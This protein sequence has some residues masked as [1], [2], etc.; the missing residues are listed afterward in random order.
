MSNVE[1]GVTDNRNFWRLNDL[2]DQTL[3]ERLRQLLVVGS[4]TQA[5]I[6]A[7]L[8]EVEARRLHSRAGYHSLFEYCLIGLG[9]SEF[10]A[11]F[12]ISAARIARNFPVA[13]ELLERGEIHLS[14]LHLL[15]LYLTPDNHAQLLEDARRKT[16]R[17]VEALIAQ[18][19]PR[20]NVP[21]NS[22]PLP[23]TEALSPG[24]QRL[25]LTVT[26]AFMA[27]LERACDR[28]SHANPTY[29]LAV[30]LERALAALH[31]DLDKGRLGPERPAPPK[32]ATDSS[33]A[34]EI[35]SKSES[36][37]QKPRVGRT[38]VP[39]AVSRAVAERDEHRCTFISADGRRCRARGFLQIHHEQP[40][41]RNGADTLE[42]LRLLCAEHN[43]LL[44]E[45][46]FG[47][48]RMDAARQR[49]PEDTG[50]PPFDPTL[51][52]PDKVA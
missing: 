39:W 40:W 14:T 46:E 19:F 9:F 10:E 33:P 44:A 47:V 26:D 25:E 8:A 43:L 17:Q 6:V 28:L 24:Y 32:A 31:R 15:R 27:E 42:N 37:P 48:S 35:Q 12:R 20:P 18:R 2:S 21:P 5:H 30:V 52:I 1:H 38:H 41:A 22:R 49:T 7:H 45:D 29:D 36:V 51:P 3:E 34:Q 50:S 13:F 11:Y 4:R 23:R 16:K